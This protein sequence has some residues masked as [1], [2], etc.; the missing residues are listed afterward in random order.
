MK[1]P[2]MSQEYRR[3]KISQRAIE[4]GWVRLHADDRAVAPP[5]AQVNRD[6]L[7]WPMIFGVIGLPALSIM[8]LAIRGVLTLLAPAS[9]LLTAIDNAYRALSVCIGVML[10]AMIVWQAYDLLRK[11]PTVRAARWLSGIYA[12]AAIVLSIASL[13]QHYRAQLALAATIAD[14]FT[15]QFGRNNLPPE[16]APLV[17]VLLAAALWRQLSTQYMW[18]V[19]YNMLALFLIF[20]QVRMSGAI[21]LAQLAIVCLLVAVSGYL[22][23]PSTQR[24]LR[25]ALPRPQGIR[26]PQCGL[27]NIPERS[28]CKRCQ[29]PI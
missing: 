1:E 27:V 10:A 19:L 8:L 23:L 11:P 25:A 22:L 29:T 20:G 14:A 16:P 2:G 28:I 26:C 18:A 3:P 5:R 7:A 15:A 21:S 4:E 13:A 24:T 9:P 17:T 6:W 12:A